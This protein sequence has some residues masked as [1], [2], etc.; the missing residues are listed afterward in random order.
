[1]AAVVRAA[2]Y[3]V[4]QSGYGS[5]LRRRGPLTT[6]PLCGRGRRPRSDQWCDRVAAVTIDPSEGLRKALRKQLPLAA[7]SVDGRTRRIA[8]SR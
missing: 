5:G 2:D 8:V 6:A 3:D 1:M 7:V 4:H